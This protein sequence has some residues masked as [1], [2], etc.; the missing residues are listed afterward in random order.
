MPTSP[1]LATT[2]TRRAALDTEALADIALA[3]YSARPIWHG[4]ARFDPDV[5]QPVRLFADDL[6]EAW[7]VGWFAG[8]TLGLHDHGASAGA[9]IVAEGRLCETALRMGDRGAARLHT[10][11]LER[12]IVRRL[13]PET[14]HAVTNADS[15]AATSIHVYSPPIARMTHFDPAS[16]QPLETVAVEPEPT[17]LPSALAQL[18]RIEQRL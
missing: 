13:P 4:V 2:R 3:L 15:R 1:A 6:L 10:R 7:V 9:I 5:R 11:S 8:Q 16:L 17:R 14:V 12:G 18:V